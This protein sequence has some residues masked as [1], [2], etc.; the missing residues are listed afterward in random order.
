MI[1]EKSKLRLTDKKRR[2]IIDAAISEFQDRGFDG[3]SMDRIAKRAEVSKRTV[4][5]H[6][7]S[8]DELFEAIVEELL[9]QFEAMEHP[10]Q[11]GE[12]LDK[13][14]TRIGRE[15]LGVLC[16]D[17]FI[18]LARVILSRFLHEPELGRK[19]MGESDV[20]KDSVKN[21]IEAAKKDRRLAVPDPMRGATQFLS[22][23]KAFGFWPQLTG[24]SPIL[25]KR[26]QNAVVKSAV[27]LFLA[28]YS[29]G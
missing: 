27:G 17:E 20:I 7:A 26:E 1:E 10:Y 3:T 29:N 2:S 21:W 24:G 13:Q 22:L 9:H 4:Y 28:Y 19:R 25:S 14:L 12:E 5:N 6:F 15:V 23:L 16:S 11:H 18:K 8:K